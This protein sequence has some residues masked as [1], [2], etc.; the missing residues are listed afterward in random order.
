MDILRYRERLIEYRHQINLAEP[1]NP[2]EGICM[3]VREGHM[4]KKLR[5]RQGVQL[6]ANYPNYTYEGSEDNRI[7]RGMWLLYLIE[8]VP[9]GSRTDEEELTAYA[10]MAR[11]MDRLLE[12]LTEEGAMCDGYGEAGAKLRVEWEFDVF[13]GWCG[14]SVSLEMEE[15]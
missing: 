3:A 1:D 9:S 10:R 12:L 5:D 8:K 11:K 4:V 13:G 7:R 6:C 14:L 15:R 2:I